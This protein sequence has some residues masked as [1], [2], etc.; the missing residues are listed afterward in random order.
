[1]VLIYISGPSTA[2]T[3]GINPYLYVVSAS[4]EHARTPQRGQG[5]RKGAGYGARKARATEEKA[6]RKKQKS[7]ARRKNGKVTTKNNSHVCSLA[8][9][10][11][12]LMFHTFST[13]PRHVVI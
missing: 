11:A 10:W 1:M 7:T 13:V 2:R 4:G 8:V 6:Q 3:P 12:T 5:I 9:L